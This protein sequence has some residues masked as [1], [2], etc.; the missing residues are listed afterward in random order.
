MFTKLNG[1]EEL[2]SVI[3]ILVVTFFFDVVCGYSIIYKLFL[4]RKK[5]MD[6]LYCVTNIRTIKYDINENKLS[7][8]F[9]AN[10]SNIYVCNVKNEYGDIKMEITCKDD[11]TNKEESN[12]G[13]ILFK[14]VTKPNLSNMPIISFESIFEPD[15][16]LEIIVNAKKE[17]NNVEYFNTSDLSNF[18]SE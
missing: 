15:K 17:L 18:I 11:N 3:V 13:N 2:I 7:Y 4:K 9:L 12:V 6:D 14:L 8:G 5:I 16:V 10:Y 1:F